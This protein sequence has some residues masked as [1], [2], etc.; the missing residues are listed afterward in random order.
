MALTTLH[1]QAAPEAM[2]EVLNALSKALLESDFYLAGGTA[3]ALL[4]GH[5][6][7]VDLDLFSPSFDD[8]E[9]VHAMLDQVVPDLTL[10]SISARTLHLTAAGTAVSL[11]GYSYPL[12][13]PLLRPHPGLLPIAS[14]EDI[15]AMKLAAIA[16]RGSRKDFVDLWLLTTRHGSLS[17]Y[18]ASYREKFA[19]RDIGH[20]VRSLTFYDDADDEPPLKMLID[21]GWDAIKAEL[22]ARVDELIKSAST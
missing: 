6:V 5:R 17:G 1:W 14:R 12:V 21:V 19:T 16:S 3:L 15:A 8:P 4:D 13:A 7:S 20:V 22:A 9:A 18:L 11:F 10:T 2:P